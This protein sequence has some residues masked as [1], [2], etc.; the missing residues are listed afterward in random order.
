MENGRSSI[1]ALIQAYSDN[2]ER[3]SGVSTSVEIIKEKET[4]RRFH[5]FLNSPGKPFSRQNEEGHFC[6]SAWIFDKDLKKVVLTHHL[7]LD[8][9]IQLGGHADEDTDLLRVAWKEA[10][11]ESGLKKIDLLQD[12]EGR[13]FP[14]DLCIHEIP[15]HKGVPPHFHYDVTFVFVAQDNELVCSD[16]SHSLKWFT[17]DEVYQ[18]SDEAVRYQVRKL[19]HLVQHIDKV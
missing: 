15:E 13:F 7:K 9:W 5:S 1:L 4:I 18:R 16:E 12:K 8:K 14:F 3:E 11:E 6:G 2:L 10:Y 17:L 19:K